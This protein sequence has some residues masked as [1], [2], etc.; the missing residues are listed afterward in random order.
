MSRT[1]RLVMLTALLGA[2]CA[3]AARANPTVSLSLTSSLNELVVQPGDSIDWTIQFGVSIGDNAGLALISV[4]LIQNKLN[5]SKLAI[6]QADAVPAGMADFARPAGISSPGTDGY[7]G[8]QVGT[9]CYANLYCIGGAQNTF[10]VAGTN[11]GTDIYVDGGVGQSGT[12]TLASGALTAPETP[13]IYIF[14]IDN[15]EANVLVSVETPPDPSPVYDDLMLY[16]LDPSSFYIIVC[17]GDVD[18]NGIVDAND[19]ADVLTAYGSCLGDL[20]YNPDADFNRDDCV[21]GTDL[22][23]VLTNYGEVCTD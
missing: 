16:S 7:C 9:D 18:G 14:Q 17:P 4:D 1:K 11:M 20:D 10:G 6:P 21:D 15:V 5:P 2:C 8:T 19:L 13:G 12:E 3:A 23:I 22:G